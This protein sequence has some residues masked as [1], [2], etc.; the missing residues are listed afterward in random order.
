[1]SIH[2]IK[3]IKQT[4]FYS[5]KDFHKS[6]EIENNDV[7]NGDHLFSDLS[8]H[9]STFPVINQYQ[10]FYYRFASLYILNVLLC[11]TGR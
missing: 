5:V 3:T 7:L 10:D 2:V 6:P 4:F 11:V 1:M 8:I 9:I